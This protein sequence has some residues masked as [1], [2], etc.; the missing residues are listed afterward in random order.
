MR[1]AFLIV[2]AL[3]PLLSACDNSCQRVCSRMAR[4][5]ERCGFSVSSE[6]V[7]ECKEIQ[8][9]EASREFRSVCREHN[10]RREIRSEWSCEDIAFYWGVDPSSVD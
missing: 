3:G 6:E 1:L 8:A 2:L 9:G 10:S 5:A 4:H 7:E